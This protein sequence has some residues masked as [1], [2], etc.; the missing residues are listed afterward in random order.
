MVS[1]FKHTNGIASSNNRHYIIISANH[2]VLFVV[3]H[4][5]IETGFK[6]KEFKK[7]FSIDV[8]FT[9][10]EIVAFYSRF[11]SGIPRSIVTWRVYQM[12]QHGVI[13]RVGKG[14]F[15]FGRSRLYSPKLKECLARKYGNV[16]LQ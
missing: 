14:K 6:I 10:S 15:R 11:E 4:I 16:F 12:V 1:S 2:L 7:Q 8:V 9:T 13:E 5:V 3:N